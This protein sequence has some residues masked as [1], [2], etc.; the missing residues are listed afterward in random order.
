VRKCRGVNDGE[1]IDFEIAA[2]DPQDLEFLSVMERELLNVEARFWAG[3]V[4]LT[5][6]VYLLSSLLEKI[7]SCTS[8]MHFGRF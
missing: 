4:A 1:I 2:S 7:D 6:R 8:Q 5:V 3:V